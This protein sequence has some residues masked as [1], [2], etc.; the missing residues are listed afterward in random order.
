M[1]TLL[2]ISFLAFVIQLNAQLGLSGSARFNDAPDWNYP[3]SGT[4]GANPLGNGWAVGVDYWIP[5]GQT[6]I[7]LLPELNFG[8]SAQ[9][10]DIVGDPHE[11]TQN[12]FSL[13][14]NTNFYVLDLEGD[15]DC[16][17][18][19][20]SGD[21]FQKGFFLQV[22]PGVSYFQHTI[23]TR[24][25]AAVDIEEDTFAFSIGAGAGL[26]IGLSDI[27]T[28]TPMAGFRYYLPSEWAGLRTVF[29]SPEGIPFRTESSIQQFWAGLRL[30]IRFDQR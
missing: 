17:T 15:C 24:E 1:R 10:I 8:H 23:Q 19:S 20:K 12:A 22:S 4:E 21:F 9:T 30:G 18:F 28:L 7:D 26:D 14:L 11:F 25:S 16:P 13:F 6:R 3:A 2:L 29:P 5:L 27:L